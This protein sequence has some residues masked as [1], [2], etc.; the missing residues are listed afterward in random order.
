MKRLHATTLALLVGCV[1]AASATWG[2][3]GHEIAA[4]AAVSQL[5]DAM[6]PFFRDAADQ[7]VYLNPEPD[8]WR[9]RD[10]AAMDEAWKYD[11]YV[12]FEAVPPAALEAPDR[13]T[14]LMELQRTTE[15]ERPARGAGL[16]PYRMLELYQ[17][18]VGQF[19]LWRGAAQDSARQTWIEQRI[20][21]DAGVLGH[22]VTDGAN[23]HHTSV[24]HN[25]WNEAYPNPAG[26]T[27]DRTFHS[28][29]ESRFVEARITAEDVVPR[30]AA[31][32]RRLANVATDIHAYL[33]ASH[34][35]LGR[36]YQLEQQQPFG[37]ENASAAHKEF[38]VQRLVAGAEMLRALWWSA[39]LE[40]GEP[41]E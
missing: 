14:Y 23:P 16:L 5:P 39:W 6:P 38:A 29:F 19:R 2:R 24:H 31:E 32:P 13:F 26:F 4:R 1:A 30:I 21:Q 20:V 27:T 34:A 33:R 3:A 37:P 11:H 36:L 15:L 35:Q 8:R 41:A 22:Y 28:R 17:R 25:G 7:L 9:D 18:L 40:S 10:V 12:D